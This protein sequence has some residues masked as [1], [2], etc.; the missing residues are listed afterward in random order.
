MSDGTE[1]TIQDLTMLAANRKTLE[2]AL[3]DTSLKDGKKI[4]SISSFGYG[5]DPEMINVYGKVLSQEQWERLEEE[6][7]RAVK[8]EYTEAEI[9]GAV[10]EEAV[11]YCGGTKN[12]DQILEE[13]QQQIGSYLK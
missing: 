13:T 9:R 7:G 6:I 11:S 8:A 1:E 5:D 2:T 12:M 10:F 3:L 4:Y